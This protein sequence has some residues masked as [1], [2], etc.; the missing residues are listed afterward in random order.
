MQE[1]DVLSFGTES[2]LLVNES[3]PSCSA[4]LER[5]CEI[6][7]D[8]THMVNA[9]STFGDEFRDRR[10]SHGGLEQLDQGISGREASDASAVGII[11]G[12]DVHS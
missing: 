12:D 10:V 7:H 2:R 3:D 1:R 11:E 9:W 5:S 8:E 4:A 6:I